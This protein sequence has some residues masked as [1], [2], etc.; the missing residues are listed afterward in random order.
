MRRVLRALLTTG[1]ALALLGLLT[2]VLPAGALD[3]PRADGSA[4]LN[5]K[6]VNSI[7]RASVWGCTYNFRFSNF[8]TGSTRLRAI[9]FAPT[10]SQKRELRTLFDRNVPLSGGAGQQTF[11]ISSAGVPTDGQGRMRVKLVIGSSNTPNLPR[12][13]EYVWAAGC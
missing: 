8:R 2:Q 7:A 3:L 6:D 10:F 4:T 11:T 9:A 1:L 12:W 13:Y 5:G